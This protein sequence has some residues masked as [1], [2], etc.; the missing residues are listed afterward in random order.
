MDCFAIT[1]RQIYVFTSAADE[2]LFY[3]S[4]IYPSIAIDHPA[5]DSCLY[6][7]CGWGLVLQVL[8]SG[9]CGCHGYDLTQGDDF[10]TIF[11]TMAFM[12]DYIGDM[13]DDIKRKVVELLCSSTVVDGDHLQVRNLTC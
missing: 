5:I 8:S 2:R 10:K 3:L 6:L 7:F 1:N 12:E 4:L 9:V 13:D 11:E